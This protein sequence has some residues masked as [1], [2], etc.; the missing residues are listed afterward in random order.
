MW[1]NKLIAKA[2]KPALIPPETESLI[3]S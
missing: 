1:K 2:L 3:T